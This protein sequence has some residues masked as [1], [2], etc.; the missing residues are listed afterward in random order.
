[1]AMASTTCGIPVAGSMRIPNT[2]SVGNHPFELPKSDGD[3]AYLFRSDDLVDWEYVHPFYQSDRR[4]TEENEDC[5]CPDFFPIGDKYMLMFISHTHGT[6]YYLGN[7]DGERF[8]PS[9]MLV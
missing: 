1:M 6:Q 5:S 3:A 8:C 4:W 9:A 7:Y 2:P